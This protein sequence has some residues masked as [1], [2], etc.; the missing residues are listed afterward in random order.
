MPGRRTVTWPPRL[1]LN[2]YRALH[3]RGGGRV[4]LA[5]H[6]R[7]WRHT[8]ESSRPGSQPFRTLWQHDLFIFPGACEDAFRVILG[9]YSDYFPKEH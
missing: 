2:V 8:S 6:L 3:H 4:E 9:T 1:Q 7:V 5:T